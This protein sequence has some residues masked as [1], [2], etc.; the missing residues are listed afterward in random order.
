M[1]GSIAS[2]A[3][4]AL[5]G[6]VGGIAGGMIGNAIDGGKGS[7]QAQAFEQALSGFAMQIASDGMDEMN[8][9]MNDTEEDFE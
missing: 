1:F 5:A 7:Q 6:P 9:A 2:M 3:G 4:A 8:Q